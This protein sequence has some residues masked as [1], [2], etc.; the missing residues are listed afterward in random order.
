MLT[1]LY[2][3]RGLH[4]A[5]DVCAPYAA[6]GA[7]HGYWTARTYISYMRPV[8]ICLILGVPSVMHLAE[9]L[10]ASVG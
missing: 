4:A 7:K 8:Y 10:G 3:R 5:S 6:L 1:E 2:S 9:C